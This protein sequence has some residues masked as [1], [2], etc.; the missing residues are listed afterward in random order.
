M[1]KLVIEGGQPLQ[2][3]VAI[4]GA[5]NAALPILF[6]SLLHEGASTIGNLPKLVDIRTTLTLL[7]ELGVGIQKDE[8]GQALVDAAKGQ[9]RR[10]AALAALAAAAAHLLGVCCCAWAASLSHLQRPLEALFEQA[11]GSRR[12]TRARVRQ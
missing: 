9:R 5:K 12:P 1:D 6:A 2:G 10:A 11:Q 7:I 3:E 8:S 4:S